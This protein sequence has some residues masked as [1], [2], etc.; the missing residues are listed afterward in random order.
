M[1]E[2]EKP[3]EPEIAEPEEDQPE[4]EQT[5]SAKEKSVK[6]SIL[7]LASILIT[8]GMSFVLTA[9]DS[10]DYTT[11]GIGIGISLLGVALYILREFKLK[12]STATPAKT[13]KKP[14]K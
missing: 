3:A 8:I 6:G 2:D 9:R 11:L 5:I 4:T 14:D 13:T 1:P 10:S 7:A 12:G